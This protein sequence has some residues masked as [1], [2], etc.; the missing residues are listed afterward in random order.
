MFRVAELKI[1]YDGH[2]ALIIEIKK[3]LLN[4]KEFYLELEFLSQE[5]HGVQI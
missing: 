5:R 2:F 4:D 1:S 3:Q